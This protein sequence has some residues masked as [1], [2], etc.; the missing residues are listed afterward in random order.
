MKDPNCISDMRRRDYLYVT[1]KRNNFE[2]QFSPEGK[3]TDVK[4]TFYSIVLTFRHRASCI[5]V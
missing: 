3:V 1:A 2:I 5:L 4:R